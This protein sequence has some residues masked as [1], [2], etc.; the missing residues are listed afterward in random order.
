MIASQMTYFWSDSSLESR[1]KNRQVGTDFPKQK[2]RCLS[3]TFIAVMHVFPACYS[4]GHINTALQKDI[5]QNIH[6]AH[7]QRGKLTERNTVCFFSKS[8]SSD[9]FFNIELSSIDFLERSLQKRKRNGFI[10][11]F[12]RVV[13]ANTR[14]V[15]QDPV[16]VIV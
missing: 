14:F 12:L 6:A 13:H 4:C 7:P 10:H 8:R 5:L 15:N 11:I 1:V 3:Y 9:D 2:S 16:S